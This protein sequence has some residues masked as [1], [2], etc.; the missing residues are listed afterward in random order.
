MNRHNF[1]LFLVFVPILL[2]AESEQEQIYSDTSN[3]REYTQYSLEEVQNNDALSEEPYRDEIISSVITYELNGGRF[4]DNLMSY[5]RAKWLSYVYGI[6]VH[7]MPF[8]YADQLM[9]YV[10][11]PLIC[12][13]K[14]DHVVRIPSGNFRLKKDSNTA[15]VNH[16]RTPVKINWNNLE[17]V[18][19]LKELIAPRF[20][21]DLV[22]VPEGVKAVAAHVRTGGGYAADTAHEKD[23]CP[24]RFAPY[25][26]YIAQL[27]RLAQMYSDQQLYVYIFT[28]HQKP[29]EIAALFSEALNN[30]RIYFDYQ[31][32]ENRHDQNVL[33]D[34]FS[35]MQFDVLLRPGSHFSRFVERLGES[36]LV[37]YPD[38]VKRTPKG[39]VITQIGI[40]NKTAKGTWKV[41][42]EKVNIRVLCEN[43]YDQSAQ[44]VPFDPLTA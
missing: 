39:I 25:S 19:G 41:V 36:Q 44:T 32:E 27:K 14:F 15:Y 12:F 10:K 17:F 8:M 29:E 3:Y 40:K 21:L 16:W 26:F 9:F 18:N 23:R 42:K 34:F 31:K 37:I 33:E 35:M 4:G 1:L 24:L 11:E 2:W 13:E 38:R 28:D 22:A 20:P 43:P 7:V 6:P 30:E 5:S